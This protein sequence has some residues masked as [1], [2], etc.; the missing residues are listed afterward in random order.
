MIAPPFLS[1]PAVTITVDASESTMV[2]GGEV[3]PSLW[4][5]QLVFSLIVVPVLVKPPGLCCARSREVTL[6]GNF[7]SG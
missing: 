2:A 4:E 7:R 5:Y 6:K 1:I 3:R